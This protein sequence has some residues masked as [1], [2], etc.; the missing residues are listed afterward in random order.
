MKV[1]LD[2]DRLLAEG[3]ITQA[4][5]TRIRSLGDHPTGSLGLNILIGFGV[6]ATAVGALAL[7]QSAAASVQIGIVLAAAG[8][9]AKTRHQQGWGVLGAMLLLVGALMAAGGIVVLVEGVAGFI[10]ITA[11]FA[12][13]SILAQSHLMAV[14]SALAL[15]AAIGAATA[16]EHASYFLIIRQPLL[17]IVIFGLLS[18]GTYGLSKRLPLAYKGIAVSFS[19]TSLFLVN[20]GFWV[21]SLWGD[22]LWQ[23][24]DTWALDSGQVIPAD[25]FVVGWTTGL[26]ATGIWAARHN[27]RWVVNLLTVFGAIHFYTQYFERLGATPATIFLGGLAALGI[28]FAIARY[29]LSWRTAHSD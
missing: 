1:V 25:V 24:E 17:T 29:N 20:L 12:M 11:L 16:Y 28:A 9:Y 4:E 22:S 27:K 2:I 5:Y 21:G 3:R 14:L 13:V 18:W 26:V 10:I 8:I 19:R 6:I 15:S 23:I 7:L